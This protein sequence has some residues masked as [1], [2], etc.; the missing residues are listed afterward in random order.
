[1]AK[2]KVTPSDT[3]TLI[4]TKQ[5]AYAPAQPFW[6]KYQRQILY[7]IGGVLL[8]G[9][10]WWAY[11]NLI[12]EPKNQE[13]INVMWQAQ[14]QFERDSFQLALENP[15]GGFDGFL[16]II[17][18]YSG[19][20]AGNTAKYYAGVC[21]LQMNDLDNALKYM[22]AYSATGDVLSI[23]KYGI[24]GDIYSEKQDFGKAADMYEKASETGN[25][26]VL[27]GMYLKRLGLLHEHQGNKDAARKAYERLR[28]EFP[29]QQNADWRDAEKYLYRV[30]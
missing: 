18:K 15:G 28:Q 5:E 4:E 14:L 16:T 17:D 27:A 11:K 9:A 24:L 22:E 8:L 19:T 10:G 20:A 2:R 26:D 1:M 7:A 25:N 3:E 29:N 13:A 12:V 23:M 30:Q 21:Y 6:E